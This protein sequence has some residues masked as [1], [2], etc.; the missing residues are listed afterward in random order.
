MFCFCNTAELRNILPWN[1]LIFPRFCRINYSLNSLRQ[2]S[3]SFFVTSRTEKRN[4]IPRL[5]NS[6]KEFNFSQTRECEIYVKSFFRF[7]WDQ[8]KNQWNVRLIPSIFLYKFKFT[9]RN[10]AT[11]KWTT[12]CKKEPLFL[13]HFR[14]N[15]YAIGFPVQNGGFMEE[16]EIVV[17]Y[18]KM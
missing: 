12:F 9:R 1:C 6:F 15:V 2:D 7:S 4:S 3:A 17:L 14:N 16:S 10:L 11:M 18:C 13:A 5:S 8:R